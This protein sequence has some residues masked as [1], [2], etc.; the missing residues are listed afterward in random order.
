MT[1][2][3]RRRVSMWIFKGQRRR[4]SAY[5]TDLAIV[6]WTHFI[7]RRASHRSRVWRIVRSLLH[8][9]TLR[10]SLTPDALFRTPSCLNDLI[11]FPGAFRTALIF[12]SRRQNAHP[13]APHGF[14]LSPSQDSLPLLPRTTEYLPPFIKSTSQNP[15]STTMPTQ[16]PNHITAP[17]TVTGAS[18]RNED[19][20]LS[21]KNV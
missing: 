7:E 21:E 8:Q 15:S 17:D 13:S 12:L 5:T 14:S 19:P 1:Q 2:H 18:T 9:N 20:L 4:K 10:L 11:H 3:Q 16:I 6:R